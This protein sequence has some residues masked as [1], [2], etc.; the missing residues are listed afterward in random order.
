[1]TRCTCRRL[2]YSRNLASLAGCVKS[3]KRAGLHHSFL[4]DH[5]HPGSCLATCAMFCMAWRDSCW[6]GC[7]LHARAC[8]E[9]CLHAREFVVL[10]QISMY[11]A[12]LLPNKQALRCIRV[13]PRRSW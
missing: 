5:A 1:M 2:P 3:R 13:L 9:K 11:S 10:P 6:G 12:L 4:L 8:S 7:T